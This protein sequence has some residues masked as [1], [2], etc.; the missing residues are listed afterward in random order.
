M[1]PYKSRRGLR[2]KGV[3]QMLTLL[4]SFPVGNERRMA[5]PLS[6]FSSLKGRWSDAK[7]VRAV[8]GSP[9]NDEKTFLTHITFRGS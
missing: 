5:P 8:V 7:C 6:S 2:L 1:L 3:T 4:R 9:L